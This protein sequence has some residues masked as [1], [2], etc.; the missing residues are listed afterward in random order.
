MSKFSR[1]ELLTTPH[2]DLILLLE[3]GIK[4]CFAFG[5]PPKM[6]RSF[7]VLLKEAECRAEEFLSE[8]RK[9]EAEAIT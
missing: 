1:E 3:R 6:V 7:K 4:Q 2:K 5:A 9:G 8:K